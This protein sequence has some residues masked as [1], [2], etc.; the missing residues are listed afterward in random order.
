MRFFF[1]INLANSIQCIFATSSQS[2]TAVHFFCKN[3]RNF[4]EIQCFYFLKIF[5]LRIF[6]FCSHFPWIFSILFS[7]W[8]L[9]LALIIVSSRE[10]W[11]YRKVQ[12]Y[13][14]GV[15]VIYRNGSSHYTTKNDFG[16]V[17][18]NFLSVNFFEKYKSLLF[19]FF[20][21]KLPSLKIF[22]ICSYSLW[23]IFTWS[24]RQLLLTLMIISSW[25]YWGCRK[26]QY[27]PW[28]V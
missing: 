27:Y 10:F 14:W 22:L 25:E 8:T 13:S 26:F 5:G 23:N 4:D 18:V 3:Q 9:L 24:W 1:E 21:L 28:G 12:H 15:Y 16:G 19:L 11:W 20:V 7:W 6:L 2:V 17:P